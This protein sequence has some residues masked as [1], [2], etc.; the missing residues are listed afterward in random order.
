[1]S[2]RISNVHRFALYVMITTMA[3]VGSIFSLSAS[4]ATSYYVATN[5]S[6]GNPGTKS[7]PFGTI[8]KGLSVMGA[9][10]ILYLRGGTYAE[11]IDAN[12]HKMPVG[13]SWSNAPQ[14]KAY[15]GETPIVKP[16]GNIN[17]ALHLASFSGPNN[18]QINYQIWDGVVFEG[19][20]TTATPGVGGPGGIILNGVTHI[21]VQ[22]S[23]VRHFRYGSGIGFSRTQGMSEYHEFINLKIYDNG[24]LDCCDSGTVD[25][26]IYGSAA[27]SL[28]DKL[29]VY[30]N[31]A[32]G[33]QLYSHDGGVDNNVVRNSRFHGNG[34]ALKSGGG[35][36]H[37]GSG[38]NNQ[39]YNNLAYNNA[40]TGISTGSGAGSTKI[41][42]NTIYNN[43]NGGVVVS[44]ASN[45][46]IQNNII[47]ANGSAYGNLAD[48]GSGTI[49]SNNL[50]T[51]PLF[52]DA[53]AANFH[54]QSGS[55]AIDKGTKLSIVTSD[56]D[57]IARP[58]GSGYDVGACEFGQRIAP[59]I[60]APPNFRLT[61]VK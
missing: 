30:G 17:A 26:G 10:D 58:Q 14:I 23:E 29:D 5:G 48:F 35:G 27:N 3:F 51:D 28:Y 12:I 4:A 22:N 56:F 11:Y 34:V 49:V 21:R 57:G 55:P 50:T 25:H 13:T 16:S 9:G 15:P 24:T 53:G 54:L 6:D 39:A 32:F 1:M 52:V 45:A 2:L 38:N 20:N 31:G 43:G 33:M 41:Y 59:S 7:S 60:P 61:S 46:E 19:S 37:V 44:S 40:D 47:Y 42:N 18:Y 8:A 36:L